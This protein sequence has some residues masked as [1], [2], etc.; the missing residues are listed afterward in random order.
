LLLPKSPNAK[1]PKEGWFYLR[2]PFSTDEYLRF[3][4]SNIDNT[5]MRNGKIL[6]L[7]DYCAGISSFRYSFFFSNSKD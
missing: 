1:S 6:E 5:T 2:M 7:M 4:F 3:R